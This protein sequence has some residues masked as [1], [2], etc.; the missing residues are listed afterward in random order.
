[1]LSLPAFLPQFLPP[2]PSFHWPLSPLFIILS[3]CTCSSLSPHHPPISLFSCL[4]PYVPLPHSSFLYSPSHLRSHLSLSSYLHPSISA[5]IPTYI[6]IIYI[7]IQLYIYIYIYIYIQLYIYIYTIIYIYICLYISNYFPSLSP[8]CLYFPCLSISPSLLI[9]PSLYSQFL[10]IYLSLPPPSLYP[11]PPGP[12]SLLLFYYW[13]TSCCDS[14]SKLFANCVFNNDCDLEVY[15]KCIKQRNINSQ[16]NLQWTHVLTCMQT[17]A[18]MFP[19][20][21]FMPQSC[22]L[23]DYF[24]CKWARSMIYEPLE[25]LIYLLS[26]GWSNSILLFWGMQLDVLLYIIHILTW[27]TKTCVCVFIC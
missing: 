15:F 2:S 18:V 19:V 16:P 21:M 23:S 6:Y 12:L 27:K 20:Q 24:N 14:I 17:F 8:L 5:H 11:P 9:S 13:D 4:F 10:L 7:Y 3:H 1:M 26:N 25:S 22:S